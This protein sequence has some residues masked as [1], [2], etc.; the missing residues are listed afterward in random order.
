MARG[1]NKVMIIGNVGR[2]PEL[3]YTP[4]GAPVVNFDVAVVSHSWQTPD[5]ERKEKTEWFNIVAWG[6]LAEICKSHLS[7]GYQ[8]YIEGRLQTRSWED[9]TGKKHFRTE[10]VARDMKLLGERRQGTDIDYDDPED[11]FGI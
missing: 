11:D 5:G 3:R 4:S 7:R 1:L 8:V 2:E 9:E 6:R 10:V